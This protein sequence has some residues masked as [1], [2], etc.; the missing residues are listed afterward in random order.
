MRSYRWCLC[1]SSALCLILFGNLMIPW[2][3]SSTRDFNF[4]ILYVHLTFMLIAL[5]HLYLICY[6][7]SEFFSLVFLNDDLISLIALS[8]FCDEYAYWINLFPLYWALNLFG[9]LYVSFGVLF[10]WWLLS[11]N[12]F[13]SLEG[14][15]SFYFVDIF[16]VS[17]ENLDFIYEDK[18]CP[19][20]IINFVISYT[21]FWLLR[22]PYL[23]LQSH[24]F[25][26]FL[27]FTHA[28]TCNSTPSSLEMTSLLSRILSFIL[29]LHF[30]CLV[31][32]V[33]LWMDLWDV[34]ELEF[35][36]A[37]AWHF[38]PFFWHYACFGDL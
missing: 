29:L 19:C 37:W 1:R 17:I 13:A 20:T 23:T 6:Y 15:L 11:Y 38:I 22:L 10:T 5:I 35:L 24:I 27:W 21:Q 9:I 30:I 18:S 34:I 16:V 28:Y 3:Y 12:Q 14:Q 4:V 32:Q 2:F 36:N 26:W 31:G 7:L 33:S 25:N 8:N